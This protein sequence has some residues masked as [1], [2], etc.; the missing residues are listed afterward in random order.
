MTS[1]LPVPA[2]PHSGSRRRA[3]DGA[4]SVGDDDN[5]DPAPK[6]Q[7]MSGGFRRH[8]AKS[9]MDW[10]TLIVAGHLSVRKQ[11]RAWC[12]DKYIKKALGF[13]FC[14]EKCQ[15]L[16]WGSNRVP[17]DGKMVTFRG[18]YQENVQRAFMETLLHRVSR[19]YR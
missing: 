7:K 8:F 9:R 5:D 16:A 6:K 18:I 3:T 10:S 13:I 2:G 17:T 14:K 4:V 1:I 11:S 15:L 19:Q 12:A